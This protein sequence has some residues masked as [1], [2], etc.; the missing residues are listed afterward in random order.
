[1]SAAYSNDCMQN[2]LP[3]GLYALIDDSLLPAEGLSAAAR[4]VCQGGA[5]VLQL[6]LKHQPDRAALALAREVVALA[7]ATQT[8]VIIND[9][10]DLALLSGADGVHLGQ[11]D[12]PISEARSVLGPRALI[13]ATCRSLE[14]LQ[15]ARDEGADH[16][17]LGPVFATTTK[18]VDAPALGLE[19]LARLCAQSPVPVV[20]IAGITL[21]NIGRVAR[22]GAWG[23]AVA[24]GLLGD[25]I[26]A[27]A[28]ALQ[29]AFSGVS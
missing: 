11:D 26:G 4:A 12:L 28:R 1:M 8:R 21:E 6:R 2:K 16:A 15:R 20:A 19:G 5:L 13:G 22:A 7:R 9:R 14:D 17:G 24:S 10:A 27:R 3:R 25:D 29:R 18:H 23:A